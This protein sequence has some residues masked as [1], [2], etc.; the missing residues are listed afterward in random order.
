ME[1]PFDRHPEFIEKDNRRLRGFDPVNQA[2]LEAKYAQ[3]RK[4][5]EEKARR[6]KELEAKMSEM[7]LS[8]AQKA[9]YK[10]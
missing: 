5:R 8:D 6:R 7:Q 10:K 3:M 1:S 2:F 9:K 4:D